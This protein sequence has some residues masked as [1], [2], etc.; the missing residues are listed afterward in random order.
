MD[1]RKKIS[2][3]ALCWRLYRIIFWF[4]DLIFD[5]LLIINFFLGSHYRYAV[6]T[7]LLLL[8][9]NVLAGSY[10]VMT[11]NLMTF[12]KMSILR[13]SRHMC[14]RYFLTIFGPGVRKIEALYFALKRNR[15]SK[16]ENK[17]SYAQNN[18]K[19]EEADFECKILDLVECFFEKAPQMLLSLHF[20]LQDSQY[21]QLKTDI[22]K[23][24]V[25]VLSLFRKSWLM[26][27]EVGY[28]LH[29]LSSHPIWPVVMVLKDSIQ[30]AYTLFSHHKN[31]FCD[32][33]SLVR[34]KYSF[35]GAI[36]YILWRVL[37]MT[38]RVQVLIILLVLGRYYLLPVMV[39]HSLFFA[40]FLRFTRFRSYYGQLLPS[41][42]GVAIPFYVLTFRYLCCAAMSFFTYFIPFMLPS[43]KEYLFYYS[44]VFI[45][46]TAFLFTAFFMQM[47]LWP[48]L[49]AH[50]ITFFSSLAFMVSCSTPN[51]RPNNHLP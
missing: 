18:R 41:L 5:T 50:Y 51:Q 39:V 7:T 6:L 26:F 28:N 8:L 33:L 32:R 43:K 31:V 12:G 17:D 35:L 22:V 9:T 25:M 30:I 40:L 34:P 15:A 42:D 29:H 47:V 48:T 19:L 27:Q 20:V 11:M 3:F 21:S 13:P 4:L 24:P 44:I 38:S 23:D 1:T 46:N 14:R 2:F 36:I 45:E 49:V 16:E 37:E 10:L